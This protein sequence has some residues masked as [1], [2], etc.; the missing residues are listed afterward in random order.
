MAL[1]KAQVR[2]IL[3][4][5]GVNSENM[6][7]AVDKII[8][9]HVTSINALREE[10]ANYKAD[11][12]KL[13][14]IQKELDDLKAKGDQN[15][16]SQY[17]SEKKAFE[18]YKAGIAAKESKAEKTRLYRDLL[19]SLKVDEKRFDAILR[20]TNLDDLNVKDGALENEK[21][22][23]DAAKKDWADFIVNERVDPARV[24][25]PPEKNGGKGAEKSRAAQIAEEYRKAMYGEE[26]K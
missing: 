24:D 17:E 20:V 14:G 4:A 26:S 8:D 25:N 3:S 12:E 13:P 7:L 2:E 10:I 15:W 18:D 6:S 9:G 1:T 5:A 23:S 11:A 16:Q 21:A 22:L 19:K